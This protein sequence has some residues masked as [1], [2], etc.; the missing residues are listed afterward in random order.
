M[1]TYCGIADAHGLESFMECKGM[2]HA[3]FTL[4]MRAS[5]N[6]QRHAMVY[7]VE[8]PDDKAEQMNEA[9][10]QAQEDSNWHTPLLLL[11]NPDFC[12]TVSFE[13]SMKTSWEMLPDDK[14]DPY[15]GGE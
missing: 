11:K 1:K 5:L 14:L 2:G 9:I 10:K 7:W 8:L 6:R 15:W 4:T 12:D 3:P 13:D